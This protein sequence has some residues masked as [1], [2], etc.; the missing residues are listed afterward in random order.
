MSAALVVS[1]LL[2]RNVRANG[3]EIIADLA[4]HGYYLVTVPELEVTPPLDA[5]PN[6]QTS[7]Y[8]DTLAK[9][10]LHGVVGVR[11]FSA[12]RVVLPRP[13]DDEHFKEHLTKD[14]KMQYGYAVID[15]LMTMKEGMRVD[16]EA[17]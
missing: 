17:A 2:D 15:H 9:Y 8:E 3:H 12:D 1:R 7:R 6:Y 13:V 16:G 5:E 11:L 4:K 10:R 14:L